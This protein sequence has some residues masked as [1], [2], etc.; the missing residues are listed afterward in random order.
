MSSKTPKITNNVWPAAQSASVLRNNL[1]FRLQFSVSTYVNVA[2]LN[3][4]LSF[5]LMPGTELML[6]YSTRAP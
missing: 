6:H 1:K 4:R 2:I 5:G 3:G